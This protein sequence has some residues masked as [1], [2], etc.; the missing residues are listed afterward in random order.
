MVKDEIKRGVH[1]LAGEIGH[2]IINP[3]DDIACSCGGR[4]CFEVLVST[5]RVL[6]KA[7]MMKTNYPDSAVFS[8]TGGDTPQIVT[9]FEAANSGDTLARL[10]LDDVIKWFTIGI[11]NIILMYDPEIVIIQG[12]YSQAG[13]YFLN[14]L[15]SGVNTCSLIRIR[16]NVEIQYSNLG[17]NRGVLGG[18][19]FIVSEYFNNR[20]IYEL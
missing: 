1:Y 13:P 20:D 16:K 3:S 17:K 8:D 14:N 4:G 18:G 6:E 10:L 2:M 5:H 11:S 19:A 7:Q 15:R 12:V 9:I